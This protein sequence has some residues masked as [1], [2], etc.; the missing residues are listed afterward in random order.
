LYFPKCFGLLEPIISKYLS[1]SFFLFRYTRLDVLT[2][3]NPID[4]N[5]LYEDSNKALE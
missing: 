4:F 2:G 5:M 3:L 1:I